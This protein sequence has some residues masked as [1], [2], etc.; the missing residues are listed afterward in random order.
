MTLFGYRIPAF[1]S[2]LL[3]CVIWEIV[4]RSEA[5]FVFPPITGVFSSLFVIVQQK[6]G[7]LNTSVQ[8]NLAGVQVV[9]AFVRE[10]FEIERFG[11]FN[12][13]YPAGSESGK[14]WSQPLEIHL[15]PA[16]ALDLGEVSLK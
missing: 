13:D 12:Q 4:G 5:L 1:V 7:G 6:L 9:K 2:I 16:Q 10:R 15:Q 3:W 11:G 14:L 8:E